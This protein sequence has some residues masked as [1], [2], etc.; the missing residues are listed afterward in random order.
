MDT[1]ESINEMKLDNPLCYI[2]P[3]VF[4]FNDLIPADSYEVVKAS[5]L[6]YN[7]GRFDLMIKY[8]YAAAK[9]N[10]LPGRGDIQWLRKL[11]IEQRRYLNNFHEA[12][13]P[14]F[15]TGEQFIDAFDKLIEVCSSSTDERLSTI[16]V[17]E[18]NTPIDGAHR[19]AV[20]AAL[21]REVTLVR[22][23][24]KYPRTNFTFDYQFFRRKGLPLEYSD[25]TALEYVRH[26]P[27]VYAMCLFPS[28]KDK[29][30][31]IDKMIRNEVSV[32]YDKKVALT[33]IGKINFI[34][35]LYRTEQWVGTFEDGFK[36]VRWKTEQ[37]F[38]KDGGI[39]VYIVVSDCLE[40]VVSLKQHIRDFC[41]LSNHSVHSTDIKAT[42]FDMA[43]M[44]LHSL[45]TDL[46]NTVAVNNFPVFNKLFPTYKNYLSSNGLDRNQFCIDGSAILSVC[47]L[48]DCRDMDFLTSVKE[49]E[50]P[51]FSDDVDCHNGYTQE[52]GF[53]RLLNLTIDSIVLDPRN[54]FYFEGYKVMSPWLIYDIKVYR[55][56][57]KDIVDTSLLSG[58]RKQIELYR[59]HINANDKEKVYDPL[60][61]G[62]LDSAMR[63]RGYILLAGL[64]NTRLV[65][66]NRVNELVS[67]WENFIGITDHFSPEELTYYFELFQLLDPVKEIGFWKT[68]EQ[69][70]DSFPNDDEDMYVDIV[71]LI[72]LCFM[73]YT[74]NNDASLFSSFFASFLDL[75]SISTNELIVKLLK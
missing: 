11:F 46:L 10:K 52:N 55:N 33:D 51:E 15:S 18:D 58:L 56:E 34:H 45:T 72:L 6:L 14:D 1:H 4:E 74:K 70:S 22:F 66:S 17:Y 5:S 48:R 32:Y 28:C 38:S 35:N 26:A 67:V 8:L 50:L 47:S 30:N 60:W 61:Y 54:Y 37:C 7:P 19:I 29:W 53:D 3:H 41:Q 73:L 24:K 25:Y 43:S 62:K 2:E 40:K 69:Y 27:D 65:I 57:P 36:G 68:F 31:Q 49:D 59:D 64:L 39:W 23:R 12:N 9:L 42:T 20:L 13:Y 21:D 71:S 44:T 16:P 63:K 75:P